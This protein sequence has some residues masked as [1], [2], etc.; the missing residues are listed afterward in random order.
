MPMLWANSRMTSQKVRSACFPHVLGGV[1]AEA[2]E[3]GVGDP[4]AVDEGQAGQGR[5]DLRVLPVPP[6]VEVQRLQAEHVPLDVLGVVVP[7]GDV[8][9]AEIQ[10]GPLEFAGPD[11][12]VRPGRLHAAP[13]RA[14]RTA[15]S[16]GRRGR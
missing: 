6:D 12:P 13:A 7:V 2:V 8:P 9:L 16:A 10:L 3:V 15:A 14:D 4:E 1:D 11:R 5:R